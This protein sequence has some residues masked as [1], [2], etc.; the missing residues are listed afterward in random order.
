VDD[1]AAVW[2]MSLKKNLPRLPQGKSHRIKLGGVQT[3]FIKAV[4]L[5]HHTASPNAG[6]QWPTLTMFPTTTLANVEWHGRALT[7]WKCDLPM[8]P[9]LTIA[10]NRP[11]APCGMKVFAEN[12]Q[13]RFFSSEFAV[14]LFAA[15]AAFDTPG[16]GQYRR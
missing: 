6:E 11:K 12:D 5:R 14:G 16:L 13:V 8:Q 15:S 10:R 3:R 7:P 1:S 4:C 2:Q 9:P